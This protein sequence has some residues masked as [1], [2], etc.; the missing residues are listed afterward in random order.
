MALDK[1]GKSISPDGN[2]NTAVGDAVSHQLLLSILHE[3]KIMNRH[4]YNITD[5]EIEEHKGELFDE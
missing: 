2:N 1:L 4:L 5:E 3:L